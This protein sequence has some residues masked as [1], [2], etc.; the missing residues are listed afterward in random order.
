MH[1]A[2]L[3]SLVALNARARFIL[4][5]NPAEGA[6]LQIN[7]DW[8]RRADRSPF[9]ALVSSGLFEIHFSSVISFF[10]P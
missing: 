9:G 5:L 10:N 6:H 7:R 8:G 4:T 2:A 3:T 1:L